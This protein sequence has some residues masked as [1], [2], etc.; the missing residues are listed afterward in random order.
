MEG[1]KPRSGQTQTLVTVPRVEVK[2][3]ATTKWRR[4]G[5][6]RPSPENPLQ[7]A[8]RPEPCN[9]VSYRLCL[10]PENPAG[11]RKANCRITQVHHSHKTPP[12]PARSVFTF[13]GG[14]NALSA[15]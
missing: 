15:Q 6:A 14:T 7:K 1:S 12:N 4:N 5:C 9:W 13:R 10:P 2:G 11:H 3:R 8:L